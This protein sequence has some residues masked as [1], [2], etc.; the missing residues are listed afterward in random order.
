MKS[1]MSFEKV[2]KVGSTK[3]GL[4]SK[5]VLVGGVVKKCKDVSKS[6]ILSNNNIIKNQKNS[7]I[8][9][10][11]DKMMTNETTVMFRQFNKMLRHQSTQ[12]TYWHGS[13]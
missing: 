11:C 5:L 3:K 13:H 10:F 6:F 9:C 2:S 7:I 4:H 12:L 8:C 1:S